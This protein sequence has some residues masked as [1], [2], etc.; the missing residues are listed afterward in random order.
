MECGARLTRNRPVFC[1]VLDVFC[2]FS[3]CRSIDRSI[4]VARSRGESEESRVMY[5]G[6]AYIRSHSQKG[7]WKLSKRNKLLESSRYCTGRREGEGFTRSLEW[8]ATFVRN[9]QNEQGQPTVCQGP[10]R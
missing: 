3:V 8:I 9:I 2:G 6:R 5:Q 1:S 10:S 4:C 7:G